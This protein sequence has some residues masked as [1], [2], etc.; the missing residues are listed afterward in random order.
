MSR[1]ALLRRRQNAVTESPE[2]KAEALCLRAKRALGLG[3]LNTARDAYVAAL[4]L[5]AEDADALNNLAAIYSKK[6]EKA[7]EVFELLKRAHALAP[8]HEAIRRN[9]IGA[10]KR[11]IHALELA[12]NYRE[13]LP[14]FL[15][16]AELEPDSARA[17]RALGICYSKIGQIPIALKHYTR[18]INLE[19]NNSIYYND[20]GLACFELRLLSEAQGSFQRVLELDPKSVVAFTHLGLLAHLAGLMEVAVHMMR[21]ALEI[22]PDCVE[23]HNN[24]ALFSRERGE[25]KECRDHYLEAL[26]LDPKRAGI[27]SGY[28]L[29]LNDDASAD[30]AW[31]ASEHRRFDGIIARG[32]RRLAP[33]ILDAERKLRIGYLSPDFRTHS[34]AYFMAPLLEA[35]DRDVVEVTCYATGL[36]EDDMT[37][38]MRAAADRWRKV[39]RTSDNDLAAL[40]QDDEID[41]LV[42]L[43][44]HT[45]YN[46]LMMM[47]ERVAPVQVTYLGY[48]NTTGLASMDYRITDA[49]ADPEG[50]SDAWHTEKLL[51]IEGGFLAYS[52]PV[53]SGEVQVAELPAKKNEHVTFGSFNNLA[54]LNDG[55]LATWAAILG[56]I[57]DSHLVLKARGLRDENVKE[58]ILDALGVHDRLDEERVHLLGHERDRLE[59]LRVYN[60]VDLALDT[61]PYNGT[62]TTCEAMWMGVPVLTLEGNCHA[63]RVGMSLL[64]RVGLPG[65]IAKDGSD[66]IDKAVA[67]AGRIA[68]LAELRSGLRGRLMASPLMDAGRLARGLEA[69]YQQAWQ[70]YLQSQAV[71]PG[72]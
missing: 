63:G 9:F 66:Y 29:S 54:K 41:V 5:G 59:H 46:R 33:R 39:F 28:L 43:S 72:P 32:G 60:Q 18:A 64:S 7:E 71:A 69:A 6:G 22:D 44:G 36:T 25:A 1:N 42:E 8:N 58:R 16:W 67:W 27:F 45:A 19:P 57:P 37:A 50:V 35:H 26:R 30:P 38:R 23:A 34:V 10:L 14:F 55:V 2:V 4:K 21:R 12:G 61:F 52:P 53:L 70:A 68:E 56:R 65:F 51:R 3:N 31:V 48:P 47:A 15:Q 20:F 49:V 40:I 11:S 24:L 13:A 62:T 17:Q